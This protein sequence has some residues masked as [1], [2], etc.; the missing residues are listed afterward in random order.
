MIFSS[1]IRALPQSLLT[2]THDCLQLFLLRRAMMA[3]YL[4]RKENS[5]KSLLETLSQDV[6]SSQNELE[7]EVLA[8]AEDLKGLEAL[9]RAHE[10]GASL[11]NRPVHS[12]F[13]FD[14]P[15]WLT[16]GSMA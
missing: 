7:N 3:N 9:Q 10:S 12:Q 14:M 2:H 4:I 15:L 1:R 13:R 8:Q 5:M 16:L 6:L 11:V